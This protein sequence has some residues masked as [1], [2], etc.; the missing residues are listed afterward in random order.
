MDDATTDRR[1]S[2]D[3]DAQLSA[4]ARQ[5]N[6]TLSH[7]NATAATLDRFRLLWRIENGELPLV[8]P[9]IRLQRGEQCHATIPAVHHELRTRTRAVRYAGPTVR[10]P[11]MKGVAYRV[12]SATVNGVTEDVLHEIDQ[13]TL[14][15][16]S[17]RLILDGSR[18]TT[19]I[20]YSKIINVTRYDDGIVTEKDTGKD[21]VF[22]CDGDV[23]VFSVILSAAMR[24][25]A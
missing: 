6:V 13:G 7:D 19:S 20:P 15:A 11:I 2:P 5:L 9:P 18:K 4:L 23:E 21:Q 8:T 25:S 24:G 1:L 12:G 14:Y 16:T 22:R 17:K 10:V 3:E